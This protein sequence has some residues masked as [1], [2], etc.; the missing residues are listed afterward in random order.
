M[1][2]FS[3][4]KSIRWQA[5]ADM[6]QYIVC[7][8]HVVLHHLFLYMCRHYTSSLMLYVAIHLMLTYLHF[9]YNNIIINCLNYHCNH[10][11]WIHIQ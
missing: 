5:F 6:V 11:V 1:A 9:L 2:V 8:T 4:L 10:W 3:L 7:F